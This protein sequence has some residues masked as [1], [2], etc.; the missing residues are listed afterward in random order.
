MSDWFYGR[1]RADVERSVGALWG[2]DPRDG[3]VL[4]HV[5]AIFSLPGI[6]AHLARYEKVTVPLYRRLDGRP[7]EKGPSLEP[8]RSVLLSRLNINFTGDVLGWAVQIADQESLRFFV[9]A[10]GPAARRA[11]R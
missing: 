7:P 5:P 10:G 11:T 2:P 3:P 1:D 9:D 4:D 6:V 8:F